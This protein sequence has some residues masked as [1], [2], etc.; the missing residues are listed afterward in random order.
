MPKKPQDPP[1]VYDVSEDST[2]HTT[3]IA[4][5]VPKKKPYYKPE[6]PDKVQPLRP[7]GII[8]PKSKLESLYW[9]VSILQFVILSLAFWST[10][11]R[12]YDPYS[13]TFWSGFDK[14]YV[15]TAIYGTITS[16][17][18]VVIGGMVKYFN[19]EIDS[20]QEQRNQQQ[21]HADA[22]KQKYEAIKDESDKKDKRI[23]SLEAQLLS[24]TLKLQNIVEDQI[25]KNSS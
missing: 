4:P 17:T 14:M 2:H 13:V 7:R 23:T 5:P 24:T 19:K 21:N 20:E 11:V 15:V 12:T 3:P 6:T 10:V 22:F 1:K 8:R 18:N 25:Q 16:F 9:K